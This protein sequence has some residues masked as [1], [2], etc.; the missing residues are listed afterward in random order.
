MHTWYSGVHILDQIFCVCCCFSMCAGLQVFTVANCI[1]IL[2]LCCSTHMQDLQEVTQET[3]Y[4]NYRAEKLANGGMAPAKTS[5]RW[6]V[7]HTVGGGRG[8]NSICLFWKLWVCAAKEIVWIENPGIYY[9]CKFKDKN[10]VLPSDPLWRHRE[11]ILKPSKTSSHLLLHK[12]NECPG[13]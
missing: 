2:C 5:R 8:V 4:E 12:Q 9:N 6:V 11:C 10:R 1:I 13:M 3:H 7:S